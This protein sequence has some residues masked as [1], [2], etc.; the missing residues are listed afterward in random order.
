MAI[1]T[2]SDAAA[3][4]GR[5]A[6]PE[7]ESALAAR[8]EDAEAALVVRIRDLVTQVEAAPEGWLARAVVGVECDI[9]LR[10]A[11]L[12]ARI[13]NVQPGAGAI[14]ELPDSRPGSVYV[15]AEEWRRLGVFPMDVWNPN[16]SAADLTNP[17][18]SLWTSEPGWDWGEGV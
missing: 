5:P 9:A 11:G 16:P 12:T 4:L 10:A 13:T 3:R 6:T 15:R 1:A 14:V 8:L 17:E 2:V 18:S 7:E